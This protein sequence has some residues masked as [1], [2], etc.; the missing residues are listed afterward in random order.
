LQYLFAD[1]L[2]SLKG[3]KLEPQNLNDL[4]SRVDSLDEVICDFRSPE[5][6]TSGIQIEVPPGLNHMKFSQLKRIVRV[7]FPLSIVA[8][9]VGRVKSMLDNQQLAEEIVD[10]KKLCKVR[11]ELEPEDVIEAVLV[12]ASVV[13]IDGVDSR[14]CSPFVSLYI[15][16]TF[17]QISWSLHP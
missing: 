8:V 11:H 3:K 17:C 9:I 13:C 12:V 2:L 15:R 7:I 16:L 4:S 10:V 1:F 6:E 5:I 14:V